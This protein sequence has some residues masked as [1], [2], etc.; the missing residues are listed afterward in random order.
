VFYFFT[1][2]HPIASPILAGVSA[3]ASFWVIYIV[4][5]NLFSKNVAL[6]SCFIYTFSQFIIK[7]ERNQ[8]PVN[9]IAPISLLVFYSLYKLVSGSPKHLLYVALYIGLS[10]HLHFTAIFYPIIVLFTLPIIP[11]ASLSWKHIVGS[12]GIFTALSLPQI[13]YYTTQNTASVGNYSSYFRDYYHGLHLRRVF[14]IAHDAFIQFETIFSVP[15]KGLRNMVFL[16]IPT[17]SLLFLHKNPNRQAWKLV[18]LVIL[19]VGIPWLVFATYKGEIS[20]YYF[21][22]HLYIFVSLLGFI[23][24]WIWERKHL[25]LRVL[26]VTFWFYYALTN[27]QE[28]LKTSDGTL[29]K[30]LQ[31]VRDAVG[32]EEEI[33]FFHG[34]AKSYIYY[35]FMYTQK[36]HQPY[37]L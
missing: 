23:T 9:F 25:L 14:Q 36:N 7:S 22:L 2:L 10:F 15:F 35:Y 1:K 33:Q 6:W 34:E 29:P 26:V 32:R 21:I 31:I 13:I 3:I 5:K 28:F 24:H 8:W 30:N 4:N 12:I 17:F 11:L 16:W 20:D 19:W 18:Y 37:K 27:T